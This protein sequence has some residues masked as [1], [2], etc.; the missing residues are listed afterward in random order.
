MVAG[1][2]KVL[3]VRARSQHAGQPDPL[4]Y[5]PL[6]SLG[7]NLLTVHDRVEAL[8]MASKVSP[9]FI[10][11]DLTAADLPVLNLLRC[12]QLD[13]NALNVPVL[14]VGHLPESKSIQH[15]TE[16]AVSR[17]A[18]RTVEISEATL[19]QTLR[20]GG[21]V[22]GEENEIERGDGSRNQGAV[23]WWLGAAKKEMQ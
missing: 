11:L 1:S 22:P 10:I 5:G 7:F 16:R 20:P 2:L 23:R 17:Q 3:V 8:L 21:S 4:Y 18:G 19:N 13:G 9:K 12:L 15:L 6:Q 14:I